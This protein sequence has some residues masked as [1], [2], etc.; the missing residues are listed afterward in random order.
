M[1]ED[2]YKKQIEFWIDTIRNLLCDYAFHHEYFISKKGENW[3]CW[4]SILSSR[5]NIIRVSY[6][7]FEKLGIRN[8][9]TI[10]FSVVKFE[11]DAN[12]ERIIDF[13]VLNDICK[14][15]FNLRNTFYILTEKSIEKGFSS[16]KKNITSNIT[17][18]DQ[19][20]FDS[21]LPE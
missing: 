16:A 4:S 9:L 5:K 19:V 2:Q 12:S 20:S 10:D 21:V 1:K 11:S 14:N 3:I 15:K 7:S 8:E 13:M 17:W 18:F 6:P